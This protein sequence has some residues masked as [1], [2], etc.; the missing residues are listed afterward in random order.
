M[1]MV[2]VGGETKVLNFDAMRI[3][4]CRRDRLLKLERELVKQYRP[5]NNIYRFGYRRRAIPEP[6]VEVVGEPVKKRFRRI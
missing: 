2:T 1:N 6:F 4:Y 5:D 3:Y